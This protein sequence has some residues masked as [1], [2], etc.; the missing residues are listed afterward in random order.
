MDR[1]SL[2]VEAVSFGVAVHDVNVS[3]PKAPY[4]A[5][6]RQKGGVSLYANVPE[7]ED[8]TDTQRKEY[9]KLAR[10]KDSLGIRLTALEKSANLVHEYAG[11][12]LHPRT[13]T[14]HRSGFS[15]DVQAGGLIPLEELDDFIEGYPQRLELLLEKWQD[16][17]EELERISLQ[18][19]D[20]L[21][22]SRENKKG[23]ENASEELPAGGLFGGLRVRPNVTI[24]VSAEAAG[25]AEL[26]LSYC[27]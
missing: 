17:R 27:E 19:E 24:V 21:E 13:P 10:Q 26:V 8:L 6:P 15:A 25:K 20:L 2:R 1:D 14:S 12:L 22:T 16:A 7:L 11:L 18:M 5:F 4:T 23:G 9:V 3:T